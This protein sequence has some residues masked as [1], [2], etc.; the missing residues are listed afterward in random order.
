MDPDGDLGIKIIFA[1][2]VA[3]DNCMALPSL[4]TVGPGIGVPRLTRGE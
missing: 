2:E 1:D 3:I 4:T